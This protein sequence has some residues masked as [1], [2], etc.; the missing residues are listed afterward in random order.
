VAIETV[1]FDFDGTVADTKALI[2]ECGSEV[3]RRHGYPIPT[4]EAVERMRAFDLKEVFSRHL[5]VEWYHIP[6]LFLEGRKLFTERHQAGAIRPFPGMIEAMAALRERHRLL[7]L[8]SNEPQIIE[9]C[10]R[11]WGCECPQIYHGPLHSKHLGLDRIIRERRLRRRR[12]SIVYV[13]D[14]TRDYDACRW[15]DVGMLAVM[16]GLNNREAFMKKWG[17]REA[18]LVNSPAD[19]VPAIAAM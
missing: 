14:E 4:A 6:R 2:I 13:G 16:W 18:S 12:D 3:L 7:I 15:F 17:F 5:G 11:V 19:L 10:F 8:S 9:D 1:I